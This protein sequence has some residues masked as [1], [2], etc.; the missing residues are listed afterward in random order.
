M[1][2]QWLVLAWRGWSWP[3]WCPWDVP[4]ASRCLGEGEGGC[5]ALVL[6]VGARAVVATSFARAVVGAR[7]MGGRV[8][9]AA[10][11]PGLRKVLY[12]C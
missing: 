10:G 3:P 5:V 7:R 1:R 12:H 6:L 2:R 8:G 11:R 9:I 4:L